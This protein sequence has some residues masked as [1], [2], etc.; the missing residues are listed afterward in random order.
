ML[1]MKWAWGCE[2]HRVCRRLQLLRKWSHYD[3]DK[4]Q[5]FF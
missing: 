5:V 3:Q 2:P 1:Y 4:E